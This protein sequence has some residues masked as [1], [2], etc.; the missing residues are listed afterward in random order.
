MNLKIKHKQQLTELAARCVYLL[1]NMRAFQRFH[2]EKMTLLNRKKEIDVEM[3]EIRADE[4]LKDIGATEF[5][6]LKEII[7]QLNSNDNRADQA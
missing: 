6:S 1:S 4:F 3:W 2:D 5:E 7:N